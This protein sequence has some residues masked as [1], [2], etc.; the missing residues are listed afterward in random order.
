MLESTQVLKQLDWWEDATSIFVLRM[1]VAIWH[2]LSPQIGR[3]IF[4]HNEIV[5]I[6]E[7]KLNTMD[8]FTIKLAHIGGS[9][10]HANSVF[11]WRLIPRMMT[12]ILWQHWWIWWNQ[13]AA[14][15]TT[16][17]FHKTESSTVV[18]SEKYGTNKVT[19]P[20]YVILINQDLL[21]HTS[22]WLH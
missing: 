8:H 12:S 3:I 15:P 4:P 19:T 11:Q 22:V 16:I 13:A 5:P 10:S 9:N 18:D 21:L 14:L 7:S 2:H 20:L 17:I 6:E 1:S